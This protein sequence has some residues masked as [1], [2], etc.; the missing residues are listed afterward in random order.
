M[1]FSVIVNAKSL[2]HSIN[3]FVSINFIFCSDI[4]SYILHIRIISYGCLSASHVKNTFVLFGS[5]V[6]CINQENGRVSSFL[7]IAHAYLPGTASDFLDD[8]AVLARSESPERQ[9]IVILLVVLNQACQKFTDFHLLLDLIN[10]GELA[11]L[12]FVVLD[13]GW[14]H[15]WTVAVPS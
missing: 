4:I 3:L 12:V 15:S 2:Y 8:I 6:V 14:Q 10:S 7:G 9:D 11:V 5:G 1:F 13:P